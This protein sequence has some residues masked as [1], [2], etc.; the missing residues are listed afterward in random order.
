MIEPSVKSIIKKDVYDL[1]QNHSLF[2]YGQKNKYKNH[3]SLLERDFAKLVNRKYCIAFNSC[4]TAIFTALKILSNKSKHKSVFIPIFTFAAVPAALEH[5]GLEPITI[6]IT[7][8]LY[9]DE[10]DFEKKIKSNSHCKI[11]ILSYMRGHVP[12]IDSISKICKKNNIKVIEDCAHSLGVKFKKKQTGYFGV[13]S[14]Y[15]AQSYK[16]IDGGEGGFLCTDSMELAS[17]AIL[18]SG[19]YETLYRSHFIGSRFFKKYLNHIPPYNFRMSSLTAAIIRPQLKTLEKKIKKM[20][21][22]HKV[23]LDI[24]SESS[25]IYFPKWLNEIRGVGD[26]LQFIINHK[27][28]L[29]KKK[30]LNSLDRHGI[31]GSIIGISKNNARCFWNWNFFKN[32]HKSNTDMKKL[33]ASIYDMRVD[34]NLSIKKTKSLA[35][36]IKKNIDKYL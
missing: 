20:N 28:D 4:S 33:V 9:I 13:F 5:A 1:I 21:N 31:N 18:Y 14:C 2:R 8:D 30:F 25:A 22:N 32:K 29:N 6:N 10:N 17:I 27:S 35:L 23:F 19:S 16:V 7:K 15:S 11:M 24:L 26:S 12:N 36:I 3:V 34:Y